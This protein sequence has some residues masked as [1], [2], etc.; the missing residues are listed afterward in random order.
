MISLNLTWGEERLVVCVCV[1]V[2]VGGRKEG[3][4][5]YVYIVD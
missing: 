4:D 1:C 3:V 5:R 2:F